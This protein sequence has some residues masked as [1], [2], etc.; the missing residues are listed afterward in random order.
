MRSTSVAALFVY[1]AEERR[2]SM[3]RKASYEIPKVEVVESDSL[4]VITT[5]STAEEEW[6]DDNVQEEGWV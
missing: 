2:E 6:T 5:S 4:D 3:K 1:K